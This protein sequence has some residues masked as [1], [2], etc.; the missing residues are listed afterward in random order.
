MVK[1]L[2]VR[3]HVLPGMRIDI[4]GFQIISIDE[5]ISL[6]M[7]VLIA[8]VLKALAVEVLAKGSVGKIPGLVF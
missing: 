3:R 5:T 6:V 8:V 4:V 2:L 1:G 7:Y